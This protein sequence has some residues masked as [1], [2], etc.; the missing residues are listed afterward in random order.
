MPLCAGMHNARWKQGKSLDKRREFRRF[1]LGKVLDKKH[2]IKKYLE[3][4]GESKTNDIAEHINLSP[5][6]T[7]ALQKDRHE[8][9]H[10]VLLRP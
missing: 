8:L 5:A 6:R 1:F 2:M 3:E 10:R 9:Q 4:H 7:R